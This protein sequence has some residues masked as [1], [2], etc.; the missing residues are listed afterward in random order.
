M[1]L[2]LGDNRLK[3][4]CSQ[5]TCWFL[6]AFVCPFSGCQRRGCLGQD[7]AINPLSLVLLRA[8]PFMFLA[9]DT[10]GP[11]SVAHVC[12]SNGIQPVK[13]LLWAFGILS[14]CRCREALVQEPA[15]D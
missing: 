14:L 13:V 2:G 10:P 12:F 11:L 8:T 9:R 15:P 3:C 6:L 4:V 1:C 5:V 7:L